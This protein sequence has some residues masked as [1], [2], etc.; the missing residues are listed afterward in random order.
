[1]L[2][3]LLVIRQGAEEEIDRQTQTVRSAALEAGADSVKDGHL[4]VRRDHIDAVWL[5]NGVGLDLEDLH[6]RGPLEQFHHG[7]L[8]FRFQ[9]LDNDKGYAVV[10]WNVPQEKIQCLQPAC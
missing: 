4:P 2:R 8:V 9:V 3:S 7:A 6:R 1:M 5:N 10:C